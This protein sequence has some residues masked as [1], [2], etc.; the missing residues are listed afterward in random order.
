V[1]CDQVLHILLQFFGGRRGRERMVVGFKT[2][3]AT[4]A[5]HCWCCGF[6]S[7]SGRGVQ[8]RV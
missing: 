8:H 2:T 5:Y 3:Y 7:R 4:S 1:H 6:E